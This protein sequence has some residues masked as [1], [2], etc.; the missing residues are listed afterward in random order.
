[1][2]DFY[3]FPSYWEPT[4]GTRQELV[5]FLTKNQEQIRKDLGPVITEIGARYLSLR[6]RMP[7]PAKGG[8][9]P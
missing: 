2:G 8:A 5:D 7:A 9:K 1:M 4:P 3:T 6:P